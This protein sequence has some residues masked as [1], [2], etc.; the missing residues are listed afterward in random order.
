[1][2]KQHHVHFMIEPKEENDA[3]QLLWN[4]NFSHQVELLKRTEI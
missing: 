4:F 2:L 1:M 3:F